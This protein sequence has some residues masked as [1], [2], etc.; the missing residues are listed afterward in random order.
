MLSNTDI[1]RIM[2]KERWHIIGYV[3]A[4]TRDVQTGED[5]YQEVCLKALSTEE[6]FETSTNLLKWSRI[7]ARNTAIDYLRKRSRSE[8]ALSSDFLDTMATEWP[9]HTD[10]DCGARIE[11]LSACLQKLSPRNRNVV[12][13]RYHEAL[14]GIEVAKRINRKVNTLYQILARIHKGL[15]HCVNQRLAGEQLK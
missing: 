10:Y 6:K 5:L 3:V 8:T 14:S 7:V 11:A 15:R 4:V 12:H 9:T 13:L 1:A 2:L